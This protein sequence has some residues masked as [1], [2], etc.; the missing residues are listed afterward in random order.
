MRVVLVH[1][2]FAG[3]GQDLR[4]LQSLAALFP[5]SKIATMYYDHRHFPPD[6]ARHQIQTSF[7]QKIPGKA[8]YS[9]HLMPAYLRA[10][11]Q[12]NFSDIDLMISNTNGFAKGAIVSDSA[13]NVCYLHQ[14][15]PFAWQPLDQQFPKNE[16]N[17]I[18]Y[19]FIENLSARF[20]QW[21]LETASRVG[22]FIA[23]SE[24]SQRA[25]KRIYGRPS[26]IIYPP[27][28]TDYFNPEQSNRSDYFLI[29]GPVIR[30]RGIEI[31]VE[32]FHDIREK[33]IVAGDGPDFYRLVNKAPSN[34]SFTGHVEDAKLRQLYRE[35]RALILTSQS[36][37][38]I[39]AIEA[40]ACGKPVI[41]L[42]ETGI[43]ETFGEQ[44]GSKAVKLNVGN[45]GIYAGERSAAALKDAIKMI[46]QR[47]FNP[48]Q[49]RNN[50]M[51]FTRQIFFNDIRDFLMEAYSLFRR[52]GLIKLEQRLLG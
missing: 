40:A 5:D 14:P 7:L 13:L 20:R 47:I 36:D 41:C 27:V 1:D 29:V 33:L 46:N 48:E 4:T 37:F 45:Y 35:C 52:D 21:D 39:A 43:R 16:I 42:G 24:S 51:R 26:K 15:M 50:A 44:I 9:Y 19:R 31:A 38:S 49:L 23:N 30:N 11:K 25:I 32:A 10:I 3:A 22:L 12:F 18:R 28:D 2:W 6:I 34:V 8:K 17:P